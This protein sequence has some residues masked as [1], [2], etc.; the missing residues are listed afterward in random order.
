[1]QISLQKLL[2]A[3]FGH[4]HVLSC[5]HRHLLV[6]A[7]G[8]VHRMVPA[9]PPRTDPGGGD[10]IHL[11]SASLLC[12]HRVYDWEASR[13]VL[14]GIMFSNHW[15]LSCEIAVFWHFF[16]FGLKHENF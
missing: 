1:M 7:S 12:R 13:N 8:L 9:V 5:H 15:L 10:R 6:L 3:I 11:R 16:F 4:F 14:E 2:D